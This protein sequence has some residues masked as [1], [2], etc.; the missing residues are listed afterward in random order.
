MRLP[1]T[2]SLFWF[3]NSTKLKH[4]NN[5]CK[6][7]KRIYEIDNKNVNNNSNAMVYYL[8]KVVH[9]EDHYVIWRNLK[10]F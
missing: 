7:E 4:R 1:A 10:T 8:V 9:K 6:Q 5:S 2:F 3:W